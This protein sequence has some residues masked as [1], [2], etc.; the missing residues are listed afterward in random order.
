MFAIVSIVVGLVLRSFQLTH[1]IMRK[2]LVTVNGDLTL[3]ELSRCVILLILGDYDCG[4]FDWTDEKMIDALRQACS[5]GFGLKK[6]GAIH[7]FQIRSV[8]VAD[9]GYFFRHYFVRIDEL[10]DVHPGTSQRICLRGWNVLTDVAVDRLETEYLLCND[11]LN[12]ALIVLWRSSK[13]FSFSFKNCDHCCNRSEQ[14]IVVAALIFGYGIAVSRIL[15][16]ERYDLIVLLTVFLV[17][18]GLILRI[19]YAYRYD[20]VYEFI[21]TSHSSKFSVR[22]CGVVRK[23]LKL[24]VDRN[25]REK[26]R[27]EKKHVDDV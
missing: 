22:A 4:S 7:S 8:P 19:V 2:K 23:R 27:S 18:M 6:D 24:F 13:G 15:F 12:R 11:C 10:V 14:S 17:F 26:E 25:Y 3:D 9:F 20:E 21:E 5:L 16:D 1:S